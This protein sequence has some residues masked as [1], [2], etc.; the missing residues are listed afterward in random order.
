M[1]KTGT[2]TVP[3]HFS[4]SSRSSPYLD[5]IGP[6]YES[7]NGSNYR[8]GMRI[9]ERHVNARGFCHGALLAALADV[10]LGRLAGLAM[11]AR[12]PLVTIH[13]GLDYLASA[14]IGSWLE[15]FGRVDRI[16]RTLAHSSG[17]IT[18][19]GKEA[20]RCSAVFQITTPAMESKL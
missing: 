4:P 20:L 11:E 14:K 8:L 7:G 2:E 1:L 15:A 12:I 16:G 17:M 10:H 18:A 6:I 3:A 5:L 9:D 19:D 13:L